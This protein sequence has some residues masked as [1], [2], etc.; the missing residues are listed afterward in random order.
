[1]GTYI[2]DKEKAVLFRLDP[3]QY[4]VLIRVTDP[5]SRFIP[6]Q[7]E[8]SYRDILSLR[9]YDLEHDLSGLTL[10]NENHLEMLIEFFTKHRHC[11][12]MVIHC[13]KGQSRSAAIAVG[14]FLFN[15]TRSSIYKIYHNDQFFPN[16]R[17]VEFFYRHFDAD[18]RQIDRWEKERFA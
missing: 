9:F 7:H 15:D 1:M 10:F 14:W 5:K 3:A 17:I 18:I 11:R 6:L 8:E 4:N 13:D 12:N 16:R 2:L